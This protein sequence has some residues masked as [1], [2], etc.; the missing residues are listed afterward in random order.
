MRV[1]ARA[2]GIVTIEPT[3]IP[4][5]APED[6]LTLNIHV[7]E[8][9]D[10][11]K[12][13]ARIRAS[14][15]KHA[16]RVYSD[17]S[18]LPASA[19]R[20]H[21]GTAAAF[22]AYADNPLMTWE[23]VSLLSD[24]HGIMDAEMQAILIALQSCLPG[25]QGDSVYWKRVDIFSDSQAS[26]K[27]LQQGWSKD[28]KGL[29]SQ[30]QAV[31]ECIQLLHDSHQTEVHLRWIPG[32]DDV[33]GNEAVDTLAKVAAELASAPETEVSVGAT[34]LAAVKAQVARQMAE[35]EAE[36]W[37]HLAS[38]SIQSTGFNFS[39]HNIS[40]YVGLST[41]LVKLILQFRSGTLPTGNHM[42]RIGCMCSSD[43]ITTRDHLLLDCPFLAVYRRAVT[44]FLEPAEAT[45]RSA[46]LQ[47]ALYKPVERRAAYLQAL[48]RFLS[49]GYTVLAR[50]FPAK[51]HRLARLIEDSPAPPSPS[52][53]PPPS[54]I[55]RRVFD[56][57]APPPPRLLLLN[58]PTPKTTF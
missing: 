37:K 40:A 22:I 45:S 53:T 38:G 44:R 54:P 6:W 14:K 49:E 24:Q 27:R 34:T 4:A 52:P 25:V 58:E 31:R 21:S 5:V 48:E 15:K 12:D 11:K 39:K 13:E 47:G 50:S 46:I 8:R 1:A 28:R 10:A 16:V 9:E 33:P 32:H 42:N 17:G 41:A 19:T 20:P 18:F 29:Q 3:G 30:C 2:L 35:V 57:I 7:Y 55:I 43:V 51:P 26:L 36:C 56:L 23:G